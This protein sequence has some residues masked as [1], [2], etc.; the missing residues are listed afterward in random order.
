MRK[1]QC[2][3]FVESSEKFRTKMH[4]FVFF[5][6]ISNYLTLVY[7]Q[8]WKNPIEQNIIRI[9]QMPNLVIF[10]SLYYLL[11]L[12]ADHLAK[13]IDFFQ[14]AINTSQLGI[15]IG[16]KKRCWVY[17]TMITE[18]RHYNFRKND[19]HII[20]IQLFYQYLNSNQIIFWYEYHLCLILWSYESQINW[21]N[22]CL[23][24]VVP[25]SMA[26]WRCI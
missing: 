12:F 3:C 18:T 25:S 22:L 14:W 26:L 23:E 5:R 4:N 20:F 19:L 24:I 16:L 13:N 1:N 6:D 11:A 9:S 8:A 15:K 10:V 21:E 7:V 17:I 2:V